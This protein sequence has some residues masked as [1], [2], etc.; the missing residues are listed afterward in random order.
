GDQ[1]HVVAHHGVPIETLAVLQR[2][3]PMPPTRSQVSGR[4]IIERAVV[5]IHDVRE[6]TEYDAEIAARAHYSSLL[7]VPMLR[8]DGA[9]IGA[10]VIQRPEPGPFAASHVEL[11]K[12][13]ADQGV[14]VILNVT[15]FTE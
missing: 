2:A 15:A 12:T 8:A 6:D 4:A 14:I 11:L 3:Y 13:F 7:G 5:G 1:L 10:I 9:P